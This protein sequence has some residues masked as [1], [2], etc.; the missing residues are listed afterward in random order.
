MKVPS[1]KAL[2]EHYRRAL[3][4]DVVPFWLRHSLDRENG[5]YFTLLDRD[6]SVYGTTKYTWLQGRE[7]WLFA[8]LYSTVEK[9]EEWLDAARLG[10]EFLKRHAF[11][12]DGRCWF[13]LDADGSP[14]MRPRRIFSEVFVAM[15]LAAWAAASGDEEARKLARAAYDQVARHVYDPAV[16]FYRAPEG[17][18]T[19]GMHASPMVA[20]CCSQVMAECDDGDPRYRGE[21]DR[22]VETLFDLYVREDGTLLELV[23]PDGS[24]PDGPDGRLV[25]PGH[26]IESAWFLM[27]EAARRGNRELL[28]RACRVVERS[29][30]IGWDD[31]EGGVLYFVDLEGRP[32]LQLEWDMKLWWVHTETLY[33][34]LLAGEL[35]GDAKWRRLYEKTHEYSFSK[36]PDPEHGE[37]YGYLH[38]D[39]SVAIPAK[40]GRWKGAFHLPRTLLRCWKLLDGN[41]PRMK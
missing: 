31:R 36:F 27:E 37:W 22:A 29:L 30:E 18:R 13:A 24:A 38:R 8:T 14:A 12:P 28:G 40:G 26:A 4:D 17:A 20:L 39:G 33:A 19:P 2:A 10:A 35:T 34:L 9:R 32:P 21:I 41:G 3:L 6:G 15:G 23:M 25:N 5:G 1:G 11:T 16:M 7:T